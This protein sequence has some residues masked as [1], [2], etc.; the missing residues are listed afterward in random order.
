[1]RNLQTQLAGYV[2]EQAAQKQE[3]LQELARRIS[4]SAI[5]KG[6]CIRWC[7]IEISL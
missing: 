4:N 7:V 6:T 5:A 1:M 3:N 2:K